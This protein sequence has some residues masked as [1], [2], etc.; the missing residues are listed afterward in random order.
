M[1]HAGT[2]QLNIQTAQLN[3]HLGHILSNGTLQLKA[4]TL[5]VS[6]GVTSADQITIQANV[7]N[8][9]QGQLIQRGT[10]NPL[11][12]T[13]QQQLNNQAGLIQSATATD[14][15]AGS[16]NNQR[17]T[18]SSAQGQNLDVD[19]AGKL[20]NSQSGQIYAG[21]QAHLQVGSIDNS[22]QGQINAQQNLQLTSQQQI[23][24]QSGQI[25]ANG[26]VQIQSQGLNNSHGQMGSLQGGLSLNTGSDTLINQSGLIQAKKTLVFRHSALIISKA[27][28]PHK[29]KPN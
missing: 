10:S 21:N 27:R 26:D 15:K 7:L 13:I 16:L 18:L 22:H 8:N 29:D 12:L 3:G 28:S 19:V 5:D 25:V 11:N 24:N 2:Q 20:D 1:V 9:A 14:I 6:G 4:G 17:G 23:N